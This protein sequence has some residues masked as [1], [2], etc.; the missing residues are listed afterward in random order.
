MALLDPA[1]VAVQGNSTNS[2]RAIC[3]QMFTVR[4]G[5][6]H[7]GTRHLVRRTPI[8]VVEAMECMAI[9][10]GTVNMAKKGVSRAA[11]LQELKRQ[12]V[13]KSNRCYHTEV[14]P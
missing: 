2:S 4:M 12:V 13:L 9:Q 5:R 6:D 1:P 8:L 14:N 10:K 3:S 11:T 7:E